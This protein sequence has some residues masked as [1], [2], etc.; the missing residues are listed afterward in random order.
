MRIDTGAGLQDRQQVADVL[1]PLDVP[2]DPGLELVLEPRPPLPCPEGLSA[3]S[4]T[5][6]FDAEDVR[7]F[8]TSCHSPVSRCEFLC[9]NE[10][11]HRNAQLSYDGAR[12]QA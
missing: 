2:G 4:V 12:S 7:S 9:G 5:P 11:H 8:A 10:E 3:G 6:V 1:L